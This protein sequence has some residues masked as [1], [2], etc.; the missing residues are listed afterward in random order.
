MLVEQIS[1]AT[2]TLCDCRIAVHN[3]A[4]PRGVDTGGAELMLIQES[5]V[6]GNRHNLSNRM[7][8]PQHRHS[9]WQRICVREI[10]SGDDIRHGQG[11]G[12]RCRGS[13][14]G[15]IQ[16]CARKLHANW[17]ILASRAVA[18][19]K[20]SGQGLRLSLL[21]PGQRDGP[22]QVR[23]KVPCNCRGLVAGMPSPCVVDLR[24]D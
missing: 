3:R 22:A 14:H 23:M 15:S 13:C 18:E 9:P 2:S 11:S 7:A 10:A 20:G 24:R 12:C 6:E 5:H 17:G 21:A 1:Y 4:T 8:L 16:R 19:A